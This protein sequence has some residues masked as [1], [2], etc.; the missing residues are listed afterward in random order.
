MQLLKKLWYPF[1]LTYSLS[2]FLLITFSTL[3]FFWIC[4]SLFFLVN[5]SNNFFSVKDTNNICPRHGVFSFF[6]HKNFFNPIWNRAFCKTVF[7]FW[8][9]N[10]IS[11]FKFRIFII[12]FFTRVNIHAWIYINILCFN[13]TMIWIIIDF[14][15]I[16]LWYELLYLLNVSSII[17]LSK[18]HTYKF[19]SLNL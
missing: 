19:C 14:V 7:L 17:T 15:L 16:V 12:N 13:C 18:S 5:R 1:H 11:N 9:S 6:N 10:N 8:Y 3:I 2:L 4:F